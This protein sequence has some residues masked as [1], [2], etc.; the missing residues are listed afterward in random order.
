MFQKFLEIVGLRS[1]YDKRIGY[2]IDVLW[3]RLEQVKYNV[4]TRHKVIRIK[5]Y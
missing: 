1:E 2:V 4:F 5:D 3:P